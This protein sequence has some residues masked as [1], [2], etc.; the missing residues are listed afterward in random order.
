MDFDNQKLVSLEKY[1]QF[2]YDHG[3]PVN[4]Q[5]WSVLYGVFR[6]VP[7]SHAKA[8]LFKG[9][10]FQDVSLEKYDQFQCVH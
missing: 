7:N 1:D 6:H 8:T 5:H 4:I 9:R 10:D 3:H 2:L